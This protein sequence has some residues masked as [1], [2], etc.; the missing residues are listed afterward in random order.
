MPQDQCASRSGDPWT[1]DLHDGT[2]HICV[3]AW[4]HFTAKL[5]SNILL[6]VR[7][8]GCT[9]V[10]FVVSHINDCARLNV[11][12]TQQTHDDSVVESSKSSSLSAVRY[13]ICD[14]QTR[15]GARWRRNQL[16]DTVGLA[17]TRC[18]HSGATP[19]QCSYT[20]VDGAALLMSGFS[21]D[22]SS[23][24]SLCGF[25]SSLTACIL[26]KQKAADPASV[27]A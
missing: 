21:M 17:N 20:G 14:A 2:S 3:Y 13:S 24:A 23:R 12:R 15:T 22:S 9:E 25:T 4:I 11:Q 19:K 26:R 27:G 1:V 16:Q 6:S 7:S 5:I 18:D 8:I 10:C